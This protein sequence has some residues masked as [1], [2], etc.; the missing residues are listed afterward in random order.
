V[1]DSKDHGKLATGERANLAQHC[2]REPHAPF[3]I[4]APRIL[5]PVRQRRKKL[6]EEITLRRHHLHRVESE[7]LSGDGTSR[8][9]G[10]RFGD[11]RFA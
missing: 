1:V 3:E 5:T 6:V 10:D 11:F 8:K 7:S 4:A 9:V 2:A